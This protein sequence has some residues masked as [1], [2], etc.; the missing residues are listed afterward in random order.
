V[1]AGG[2]LTALN[3]QF[4]MSP[5]GLAVSADGRLSGTLGVG[6]DNSTF[7]GRL[8]QD[9]AHATTR[10]VGTLTRGF[11]TLAS[12]SMFVVMSKTSA[13]VTFAQD[14]DVT[15][16]WR[17]KSLLVPD[18]PLSVPDVIDGV[19]VVER[20]G[21][22][23]GGTLTSIVDE[24]DLSEFIGT[25]RLDAAGNVTV[26]DANGNTFAAFPP[27]PAI[28]DVGVVLFP[29]FLRTEESA[30]F[31]ADPEPTLLADGAVFDADFQVR[32][33][34]LNGPGQASFIALGRT[35]VQRV[36][37]QDTFGQFVTTATT[38]SGA[39]ANLSQGDNSPAINDAGM[40]AFCATLPA[41][42]SG[43]FTGPVPSTGKV[44]RT[45]DA[46][47]G[48]TVVEV[49]LGGLNN[50]GEIAFRAVLSNGRQVIGVAIPP[51]S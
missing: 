24:T 45:G 6:T 36:L 28:N 21:T 49:Q 10:I 34:S 29:T 20:D 11:G 23:S 33:G 37:T 51:G 18:L 9:G 14:P 5:G 48:D 42:P 15:G 46:L 25:L 41:G 26:A 39:Y 22:I 35:G 44:I 8:V 30:V 12:R 19:I 40:V 1:T 32:P 2:L 47:F 3:E 43:I 17:V 7:E 38:E 13:G 16:S 50:R 27:N 4:R 31:K